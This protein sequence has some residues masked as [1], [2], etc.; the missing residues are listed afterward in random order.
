[1]N[2]YT[3]LIRDMAIVE[4]PREQLAKLGPDAL[5]MRFQLTR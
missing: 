1:M 4:R 2:N 5:K 3:P